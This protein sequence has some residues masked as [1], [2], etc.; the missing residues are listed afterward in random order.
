MT[1]TKFFTCILNVHHIFSQIIIDVNP[2]GNDVNRIS[3]YRLPP[4]GE[5]FYGQGAMILEICEDAFHRIKLLFDSYGI[6]AECYSVAEKATWINIHMTEDQI[7]PF[8]TAIRLNNQDVYKGIMKY[9][10]KDNTGRIA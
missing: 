5:A 4:E 10:G 8:L 6:K 7:E 9:A 1:L 2:K 3:S